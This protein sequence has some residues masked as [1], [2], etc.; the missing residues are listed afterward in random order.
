MKYDFSQTVSLHIFK[1]LLSFIFHF[2]VP[3]WQLS[4]IR[5]NSH[6]INTLKEPVDFWGKGQEAF[7]RT[8]GKL[9]L[10]L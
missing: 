2:K 10:Q 9:E 3:T 5:S 1:L 4:S 7:S 6:Q 8:E